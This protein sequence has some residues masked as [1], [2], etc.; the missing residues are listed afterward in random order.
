MFGSSIKLDKALLARVKRYSDLAGYS[1]VEEFITH[2][3][4]KQLAQLESAGELKRVR[5]PVD[6]LCDLLGGVTVDV[7]DRDASTF[8]GHAPARRPSD[9]RSAAGDDRPAAVEEPHSRLLGE[10]AS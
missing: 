5:E 7:D 9:A 8:L 3:L 4:E 1:S 2:A 10:P 6:L